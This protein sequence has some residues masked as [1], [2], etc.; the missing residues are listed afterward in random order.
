VLPL[1][2]VL[3]TP[4]S[5]FTIFS[6]PTGL[7]VEVGQISD[8]GVTYYIHITTHT[9]VAAIRST[10]GLILGSAKAE[11]AITPVACFETYFYLVVKHDFF[12]A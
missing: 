4:A 1:G 3:V 9:P 7:K 10:L 8:I 5:W 2:T 6:F 12:S 11:T